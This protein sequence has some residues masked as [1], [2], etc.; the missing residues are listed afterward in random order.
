MK[1]LLLSITGLAFIALTSLTGEKEKIKTIAN[2]TSAPMQ[3]VKMKNINGTDVSLASAKGKNGLL[4]IF[5]CNTCP[6]V[7][8][9]EDRYPELGSLCKDNGM[10]MIL[11]NSN[12]AKRTGDDSMENMKA[13]YKEKGYNT[14]YVSDVNASLADAFGAK[15]T[16]HVFLFDGDLK[17]VYQGAIDDNYKS[18]D[19]ATKHYLKNALSSLNAGKTIDPADTPAKGCSIKRIKKPLTK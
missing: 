7:I 11:V 1:L 2:G 16:P 5:S 4:V 6:F 15:T 13:H 3:E 8:G 19:V 9:W 17:C 18:K 14:Y 12:A 10:G